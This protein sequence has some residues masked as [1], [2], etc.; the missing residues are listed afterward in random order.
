MLKPSYPATLNIH[1]HIL[2]LRF[3]IQLFILGYSW[4]EDA[5]YPPETSVV[6]ASNLVHIALYRLLALGTKQGNWANHNI[7]QSKLRPK[8]VTLRLTYKLQGVLQM[9]L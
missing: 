1:Y 3:L 7:V 6:E 8:A 2:A 5:S 4:L 9:H